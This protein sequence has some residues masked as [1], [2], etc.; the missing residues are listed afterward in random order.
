MARGES[1]GREEMEGAR[2]MGFFLMTALKWLQK[3]E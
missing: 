1:G 3:A 2:R